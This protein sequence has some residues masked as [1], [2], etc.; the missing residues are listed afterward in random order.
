MSE[1]AVIV[2]G[3]TT[4]KRAL[5]PV[6]EAA[7]ELGLANDAEIFTFPYAMEYPGKVEKAAKGQLLI[8]HSAG[9]LAVAQ[10]NWTTSPRRF[11]AYNG[12]EPRTKF[13][14]ILAAGR[15]TSEHAKAVI[16]G[17]DRLS[18]A[19]VISSNSV[20]LALHPYSNLRHLDAISRFSTLSLLAACRKSGINAS[21]AVTEGDVFFPYDASLG[22][23]GVDV[24]VYPGSH[25][26]L[27]VN[28]RDLMR[29]IATPG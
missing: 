14:L 26:E 4:G 17:P 24:E 27:L 10:T 23:E 25:D 20:E 15:K 5:E 12:P 2:G 22:S 1:R 9:S 19:K 11:I 28:P 18:Y 3:F 7:A 21:A 6:G 29:H 13:D 16:T 8:A